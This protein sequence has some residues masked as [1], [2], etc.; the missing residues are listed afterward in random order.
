MR[1]FLYYKKYIFKKKGTIQKI[2]IYKGKKVFPTHVNFLT[3]IGE[4][5]VSNFNVIIN[6][7][8]FVHLI[9]KKIL[10]TIV[11]RVVSLKT[12][13]ILKISSFPEK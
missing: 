7:R 13:I 5:F 1:V 8:V 9:L 11:I 4:T 12:N 6:E 10:Q 2:N 3:L